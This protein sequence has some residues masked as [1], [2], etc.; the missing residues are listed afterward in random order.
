MC[1][2]IAK[3]LRWWCGERQLYATIFELGFWFL[4]LGVTSVVVLTI[5]GLKFSLLD[6]PKGCFRSRFLKKG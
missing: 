5:V 1:Q 3:L 2:S 6:K 4:K